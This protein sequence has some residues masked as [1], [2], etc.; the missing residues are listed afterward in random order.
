MTYD[1]QRDV[2]LKAARELAARLIV[3]HPDITSMV[4]TGHLTIGETA[5]NFEEELRDLIEAPVP[6]YDVSQAAHA[7]KSKR[8]HAQV[9]RIAAGL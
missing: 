7:V 2:I 9:A 6:G 1:E 5:L 4:V 3:E 8:M